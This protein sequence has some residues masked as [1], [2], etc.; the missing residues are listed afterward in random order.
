MQSLRL[1]Q[2]DIKFRYVQWPVVGYLEYDFQGTPLKRKD[3]SE[4]GG[5]WGLT[6]E[7]KSSGE[8]RTAVMSTTSSLNH[9]VSCAIYQDGTIVDQNR[10]ESGSGVTE[11]TCSA[12]L[13]PENCRRDSDWFTEPRSPHRHR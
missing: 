11:L 5:N 10:V 8:R 2:F 7:E 9:Y 3:G 12:P 1:H 13:G 4:S 6:V